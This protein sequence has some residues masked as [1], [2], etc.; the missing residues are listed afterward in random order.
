MYTLEEL[1]NENDGEHKFDSENLQDDL[2]AREKRLM[3]VKAARKQVE[4]D[5]VLLKNRIALLQMEE[6]KARKK[7]EET[8]K[9]T[10][11]V[12]ILK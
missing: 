3:D 6:R 5:A 8:K 2:N 10:N 9:R 1:G 7:I 4:K 12:F 11:E